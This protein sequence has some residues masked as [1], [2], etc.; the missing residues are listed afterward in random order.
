AGGGD[1]LTRLVW[2]NANGSVALYLL[3]ANNTVN[4]V[5]SYGPWAAGTL[6]EQA[7]PASGV[8]AGSGPGQT[9][10]VATAV[11]PAGELAVTPAVDKTVAPRHTAK[12]KTPA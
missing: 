7:L 6:P 3:N 12:K 2:D 10:P 5:T 1:A 11:A 8:T 4:A 9:A